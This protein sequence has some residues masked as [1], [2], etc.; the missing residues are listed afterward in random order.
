M[1][2]EFLQCINRHQAIRA[3]L[4]AERAQR[5][6]KAISSRKERTHTDVGT[7]TVYSPI[8]G[9]GSLPVHAKLSAIE[10][11][12]GRNNHARRKLN[13]RLKASAI[14]GQILS[15]LPI[16]NRAHRGILCIDKR[17]ASF[18]GHALRRR[19]NRHLEVERDG[20]LDVKHNIW[21][22]NALEALL[23][24]FDLVIPRRKIRY[25]IASFVVRRGRISKIRVHI[26]YGNLRARN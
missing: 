4:S 21:L 11:A 1:N 13:Q 12:A 20:I 5:T 17:R 7:H 10:A 15:K 25:R 2:A 19:A 14:Q 3:T 16:N 8:V 23:L 6:S 9:I 26:N 22:H 18:D 24:H